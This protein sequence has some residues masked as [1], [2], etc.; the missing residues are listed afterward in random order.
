MFT[1]DDV[2]HYGLLHLITVYN[3]GA[4]DDV[5]YDE[6]GYVDYDDVADDLYALIMHLCHLLVVHIGLVGCGE[7]VVSYVNGASTRYWLT[8]GQVADKAWYPCSR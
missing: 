2:L 1:D 3:V 6:V 5:D 8:I 4:D 7:G